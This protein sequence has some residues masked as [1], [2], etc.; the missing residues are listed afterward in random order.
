MPRN[1]PVYFAFGVREKK[2][3]STYDET[4]TPPYSFFI[5][6][7]FSSSSA[8]LSF[9]GGNNLNTGDLSG[10][11]A[12]I[13]FDKSAGRVLAARDPKGTEPLFWGTSNFGESLLFSNDRRVLELNCADADAFPPGTL[14]SSE[15]GE[16]TGELTMLMSDDWGDEEDGGWEDVDF[17][18]Q[19]GQEA[20]TATMTTTQKMPS[21]AAVATGGG[22]CV[23]VAQPMSA[24]LAGDRRSQP[25]S[26]E[27]TANLSHCKRSFQDLRRVES[28][29]QSVH[30]LHGSESEKNL[31]D[32]MRRVGSHGEVPSAA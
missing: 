16:V 20:T 4:Y 17:L 15:S 21:A 1:L 2:T 18:V 10:D 8:S 5:P 11:F 28:E 7:S 26:V 24:T 3:K 9:S 23:A 31:H 32:I 12:M 27:E 29:E 14:F 22:V 6:Y 30:G 25:A 19:D 13:L